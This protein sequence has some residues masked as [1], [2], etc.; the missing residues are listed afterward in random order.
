MLVQK[1][2]SLGEFTVLARNT[3]FQYQASLASNRDELRKIRGRQATVESAKEFYTKALDSL[4]GQSLEDLEKLL[5]KAL[6][7]I[8]HD[9][10]YSLQ[11]RSSDSR[12]KSLII[13]LVDASFDPPLELDASTS[14]GM[15]VRT[16]ISAIIHVFFILAD[17]KQLNILCVDEGY[18]KISSDYMDRFMEFLG[19]L[20]QDK[21]FA[22]VLITHDQRVLPYADRVLSVSDGVVSSV[23]VE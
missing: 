13:G 7:Y 3:V 14:T 2:R 1:L 20:C 18:N 21:Q 17:L 11:L 10:Q 23:E 12:G 22:I 4:H 6:K 16:V 15:G 5:T 8:F 9:K 19:M